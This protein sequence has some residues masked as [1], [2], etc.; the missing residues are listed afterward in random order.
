MAQATAQAD[1]L[2]CYA[3]ANRV[4]GAGPD[5]GDVKGTLRLP[6]LP[7][8]EVTVR[9]PIRT[10]NGC[11][12]LQLIPSPRMRTSLGAALTSAL[13]AAGVRSSFR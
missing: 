13:D 3:C 1:A 9:G 5:V 4:W 8:M 11:G 7:A 10:C 12:R 6:G 2:S